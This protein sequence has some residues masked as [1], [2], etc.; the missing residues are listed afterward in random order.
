[1]GFKQ[2]MPASAYRPGIDAVS[3]RPAA[4][5]SPGPV[6]PSEVADH[7]Y[8][9]WGTHLYVGEF[10]WEAHEVW[11]ELWRSLPPGEIRDYVQGLIQ[12]AASALKQ[13]TGDAA[14]AAKIWKRA[15]PR[16]DVRV[17]EALGIEVALSPQG[18]RLVVRQKQKANSF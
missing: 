17:G 16:L 9:W 1:M 11:E 12:C 5:N 7:E 15:R 3:A 2:R 4:V 13:S 6:G 18:P 8:L 10:F 14:A